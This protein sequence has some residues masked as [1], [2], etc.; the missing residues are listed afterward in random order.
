MRS[1]T[2]HIKE[3]II[4]MYLNHKLST[5]DIG[6]KFNLSKTTILNCLKGNNIK[7]RELK[8]TQRKHSLNQSYFEKIDSINKAQILGM[9]Y[10]DGCL[11]DSNNTVTVAL[12]ST[13]RDYL[14]FIKNELKYEGPI[15][16]RHY[17]GPSPCSILRIGCIKLFNDLENLGLTPRK[18]LTINYPCEKRLSKNLYQHFIRGYFEGDGGLCIRFHKTKKRVDKYLSGVIGICGTYQ[19][20]EKIQSILGE[21]VGINSNIFQAKRLKARKV[22]SHSLQ[23][24]GNKQVVKFLDWIYQGYKYD[25]DFIMKRKYEKYLQLKQSLNERDLKKV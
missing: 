16:D 24:Q 22:N 18:S 4:D 11:M 23:I 12:N 15:Y 14:E 9:I 25:F 6:K 17:K 7:P 1:K 2:E 8:E 3:E 19:F 5:R 21:I 20:L 13:D 10:A